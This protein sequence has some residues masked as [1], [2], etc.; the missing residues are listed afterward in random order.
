MKQSKV[1]ASLKKK[2][3]RARKLLSRKPDSTIHKDQWARFYGVLRVRSLVGA[4][5]YI[6]YKL[7]YYAIGEWSAKKEK[8][9]ETAD[10]LDEEE[11]ESI[12]STLLS[13]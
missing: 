11:I 12:A 13:I 5:L 1:K 8:L 3:K 7:V 10:V 9:L 6:V 2:A 4:T